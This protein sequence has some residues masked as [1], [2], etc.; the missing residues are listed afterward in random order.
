MSTIDSSLTEPTGI[1]S[2]VHHVIQLVSPQPVASVADEQ[3]LVGELGYH[4]LALAELAFTLEDL[5][6]L[7]AMTPEQ[8][9]TLQTVG[10]IIGLIVAAVAAGEAKPPALESVQAI[11]AQY[12]GS[13]NP[14]A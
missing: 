7:D 10:D 3:H 5:F 12:G 14:D 4:S 2:V 6:S 9:I 1:A 8:A 13:W 11:S